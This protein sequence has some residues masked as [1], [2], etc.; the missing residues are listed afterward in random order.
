MASLYA[1]DQGTP[2]AQS[3]ASLSEEEGRKAPEAAFVSGPKHGRWFRRPS[4]LRGDT[5]LLPH[6]I[7]VLMEEG[8]WVPVA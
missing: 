6:N 2:R 8:W 5:V 3:E 1:L 4:K 7:V